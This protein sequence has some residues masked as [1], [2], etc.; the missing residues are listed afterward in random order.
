MKLQSLGKN[1]KLRELNFILEDLNKLDDYLD[2][3]VESTSLE[4]TESKIDNL[5]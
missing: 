4:K 1:Q 2:E 3:Q 5:K